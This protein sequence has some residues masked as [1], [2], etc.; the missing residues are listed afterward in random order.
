MLDFFH[1]IKLRKVYRINAHQTLGHRK[2]LYFFGQI[3]PA[4]D[5]WECLMLFWIFT[6]GVGDRVASHKQQPT[7]HMMPSVT[8]YHPLPVLLFLQFY[9]CLTHLAENRILLPTSTPLWTKQHTNNLLFNFLSQSKAVGNS[10]IPTLTISIHFITK[11]CQ[12]VKSFSSPTGPSVVHGWSVT[13]SF[14]Q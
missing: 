5:I 8:M 10:F 14:C 7:I 9:Y 1:I 13:V 12:R 3:C 11:Q 4:G 6:T 2:C